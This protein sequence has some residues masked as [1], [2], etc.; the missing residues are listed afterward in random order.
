MLK[1]SSDE[2]S[3]TTSGTLYHRIILNF[4]ELRKR[5]C[6]SFRSRSST[7]PPQS[8]PRSLARPF[9]LLFLYHPSLYPPFQSPTASIPLHLFQGNPSPP[10]N[11]KPFIAVFLFY[12]FTFCVGG[13]AGRMI[14]CRISCL[15]M[16]PHFTS[17][18]RREIRD[19]SSDLVH[20]LFPWVVAPINGW[21][22]SSDHA[23]SFSSSN[24]L[25]DLFPWV[26]DACLLIAPIH[27]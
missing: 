2:P 7:S 21:S 1:H 5:H 9:I 19:A 14:V 22:F 24:S 25:H 18:L 10:T 8:V 20:G 6:I 4:R 16:S 13:E 27:G 23:V 17:E 26:G 12:I 15:E 3:L 11:S